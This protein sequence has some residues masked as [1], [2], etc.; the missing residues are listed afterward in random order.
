MRSDIRGPI[1]FWLYRFLV[2]FPLVIGAVFRPPGAGRGF[3]LSF[4]VACGYVGLSIVALEFSLVAR[5]KHVAGAFGQD[6]LEQFHRQMAYVATLFLLAHPILLL[7]CGY[8]LGLLNPFS[9]GSTWAW[10][11]GT[12]GLCF[13]LVLMV[14]SMGY[15]LFRMTYEWWH[16]THQ[17]LAPAVLI[18]ALLH[19]FKVSGFT[20]T[21]P[22]K[23][24]WVVYASGFLGITIY[25]RIYMPLQIWRRPWRVVRNVTELGDSRTLVLQPVDHKGLSF[26]PGQFAWLSLGKTPFHGEEHPISFSSSAENPA[27]A[28]V[29]FTIKALGD[30][31]STVVPKIQPG[32][33]VWV[34]GPYGVFSPDRDQGPG[35]VLLG[36]GIGIT[37]LYSMCLTM[38]DRGDLRPILLFYGAREFQELTF[39][40]ELDQLTR[41][42]NLKCIYV[43][44]HASADWH[45]ETGLI[46]VNLLRRYL[47]R[48]YQRF[49][50]FICGPLAMM[51]AME[52]VLPAMGIAPEN[53]HTERI[54]DV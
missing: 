8:P 36:G 44:E 40:F 50:Y 31:S 54:G 4:A 1:W 2:L 34:D 39:R 13:L 19:I 14:L 29:S 32:T 20:G 21:P 3:L 43:L 33:R 48:Q 9:S 17:L 28:E 25:H 16:A 30:W 47:P 24:L 22:M 10:R 53:I 11:W 12:I 18:A 26:E 6:A 35:Y 37:P 46:N 42:M 38:A 45:G 27:G 5:L 41:R 49:Q 51:D 23:A 15:K 52:R 7:A